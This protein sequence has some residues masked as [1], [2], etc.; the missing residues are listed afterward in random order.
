M[1]GCLKDLE[2]GPPVSI[3]AAQ[4][5]LENLGKAGLPASMQS[6]IAAAISAKVAA[7]DA[8]AADPEA[9]AQKPRKSQQCHRYLQ[10]FLC[11]SD[12]KS[13]QGHAAFQAKQQT[14]AKRLV[15]MGLTN[16]TEGTY[17]LGVAVLYLSQHA[18]PAETLQVS[19]QDALSTLE[20]LKGKLRAWAKRGTHSGLS[21]YPKEP[22]ELPQQLYNTAF[23]VEGP[24]SCPLDGGQLLALADWLP[25][26][27]S[28]AT[29]LV[30]KHARSMFEGMPSQVQQQMWMMQ[31]QLQAA[32]AHTDDNPLPGLTFLPRKAKQPQALQNASASSSPEKGGD[33]QTARAEELPAEKPAAETGVL[34][35]QPQL[36]LPAPETAAAPEAGES[37]DR[38]AE[39]VQ[40]HLQKQAQGAERQGREA[41]QSCQGAQSSPQ[42]E[43]RAETE[44]GGHGHQGQEP[45]EQAAD[46]GQH[47]GTRP[48]H[49]GEMF[50]VHMPEEPELAREVAWREKGQSLLLEVWNDR[51]M[52]PAQDICAR[53]VARLD[54]P[55][56]HILCRKCRGNAR[57]MQKKKSRV[58]YA[59][60]P[61]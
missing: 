27:K 22:K 42:K 20:D 33:S 36:A 3:A 26:R 10:H 56:S 51:G 41:E 11:E 38:M 34:Q 35:Q 58:G 45:N 40:Q 1:R 2:L 53:L 31:M 57:A 49:S 29:L 12:W 50:R 37:V 5:M 44:A 48:H 25:A 52:D 17:V 30:T 6:A 15:A 4:T 59:H 14:L 47:G 8:Q 46:K 7:P 54:P 21:E 60:K 19:P 16:P 61:K 18:G 24:A 32:Q 28:K 39:L 9:R 23:A 43:G 13:L 55:M